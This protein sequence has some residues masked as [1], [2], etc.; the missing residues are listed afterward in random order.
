MSVSRRKSFLTALCAMALAGIA[1]LDFEF[2]P[3][4]FGVSITITAASGFPC[5][6]VGCLV[7]KLFGMEIGGIQIDVS[8]EGG[9]RRDGS[10]SNCD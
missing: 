2:A 3:L 9:I 1:E 8:V 6:G 5:E 4:T 7:P 10:D